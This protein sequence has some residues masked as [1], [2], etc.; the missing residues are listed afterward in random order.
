[1]LGIT[2]T[3]FYGLLNRLPLWISW[4]KMKVE[5]IN[6]SQFQLTLEQRGLGMTPPKLN[7]FTVPWNPQGT[8]PMSP[9]DIQV[10][11]CSSPSIKN[12][13]TGLPAKMEA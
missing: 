12:C 5:N 1:M 7:C 13:R 2:Y 6:M 4:D 3:A 11:G 8:G 9:T 10:C